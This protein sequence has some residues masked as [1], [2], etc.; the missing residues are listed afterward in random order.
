VI[1]WSHK[2]YETL[3]DF[4]MGH[5]TIDFGDTGTDLSDM[6]HQLLQNNEEIHCKIAASLSQVKESSRRQFDI[7]EK[8]L[9]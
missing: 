2:Y 7:L 4:G 8:L 5:C 9:S 3:E 6:A 1:G